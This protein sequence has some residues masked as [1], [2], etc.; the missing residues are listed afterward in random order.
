MPLVLQICLYARVISHVCSTKGGKNHKGKH[1]VTS[2]AA[3]SVRKSQSYYIKYSR[4]LFKVG[5]VEVRIFENTVKFLLLRY[6]SW[7]HPQNQVCKVTESNESLF[8]KNWG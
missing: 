8:F 2:K 1:A 5:P 6:Y 4:S 7:F 3:F